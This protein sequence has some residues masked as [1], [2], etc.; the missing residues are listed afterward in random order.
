MK[1]IT[2][3]ECKHTETEHLGWQ[4]TPKMGKYDGKPVELRNCKSCGSTIA[5]K[6]K[7]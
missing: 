7:N 5:I 1:Q 4:E 2:E 6:S 3:T